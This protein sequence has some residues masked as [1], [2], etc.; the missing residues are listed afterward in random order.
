MNFKKSVEEMERQD[1]EREAALIRS[2]VEAFKAEEAA[3]AEAARIYNMQSKKERKAQ[4][5][6]HQGISLERKSSGGDAINEWIRH[7]DGKVQMG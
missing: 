5:R 2:E 1:R 7:E 6:L 4:V 3:K